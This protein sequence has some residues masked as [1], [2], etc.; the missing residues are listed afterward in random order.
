MCVCETHKKL[1]AHSMQ[2]KGVLKAS[3]RM[4]H[5]GESLR[6]GPIL[7]ISRANRKKKNMNQIH[8]KGKKLRLHK[9]L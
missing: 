4:W 5:G 9:I 1:H 2:L 3:W 7:S 6:M 8:S